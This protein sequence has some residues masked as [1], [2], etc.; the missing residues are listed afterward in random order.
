MS[1][2]ESG[3]EMPDGI[4]HH[5]ER[6]LQKL[7]RAH[8]YLLDEE[9]FNHRGKTER[10]VG[11]G[12]LDIDFQTGRGWTVVECK[13]TRLTN[14]DLQ[15]FC[16]YLDWLRDEGK[17]VYKAYLIGAAAKGEL[18]PELIKHAPAITVKEIVKDFPVVL[19]FSQGRHYFDASLD[20][21]PYDGTRRIV[22]KEWYLDL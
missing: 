22:G 19:A 4:R 2:W 20:V 14:K 6:R 7:L 17:T 5:R 15:Q 11:S 12:R 16:G 9:L 21:C 13:I 10:R 8:P 1:E 3:P 18:D